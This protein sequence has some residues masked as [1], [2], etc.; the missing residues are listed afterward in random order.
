MSGLDIGIDLGTT[1]IIV[2]LGG[3]GI[4]LSEPSVVAMDMRRE[5]VLAVGER[6]FEMI[7]KTP[8]YIV[9]ERPLKNGVISNHVLTEY[10]IREYIKRVCGT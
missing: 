2:Y 3:K 1:S 4:V 10:M 9:A 6:A 5:E 7:G 8:S